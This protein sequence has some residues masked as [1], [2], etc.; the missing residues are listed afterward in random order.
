MRQRHHETF[1]RTWR[2]W[3]V[4][5]FVLIF[6][7]APVAVVAL[8]SFNTKN[9]LISFEGYSL[10]W[11]RDLFNDPSMIASLRISTVIAALTAAVSVIL[12]T[13]LAFGLQ[14]G[15]RGAA[16]TAGGSVFLRLVTPETATGA[17]L[18]LLFSQLKV[19]LSF[20][21][22]LIG[23]VAVCTAL[24]TVVVRSRLSAMNSEL[25]F[26][27]QDLGSRR[28]Q[29]LWLVVIPPLTPTLLSAGMLA[30]VLS[31]DNFVTTYFTAGT[32]TQPLPLRI[33]SMLRFG[34][35]PEVNAAGVVMLVLVACVLTATAVAVV[36]TRRSIQARA[37]RGFERS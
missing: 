37:I 5:W 7:M 23:H 11:Y 27:A 3:L 14:R 21:T 25:E 17:S 34:V 32:G 2:L 26:A 31:F 28:L 9:S 35:T 20:W 13:L 8:Y 24:V 33:Y 16:T 12:G 1:D 6:L 4:T 15:S 10:R 19:T 30:F 18:F 22:I 29:S 36:V